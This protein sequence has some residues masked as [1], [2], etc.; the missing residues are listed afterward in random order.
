M[1][2][3][4]GAARRDISPTGPVPL[5]GY[6]RIHRISTGIHDPLLAAA[7]YLENDGHAILLG[8]LD[9]IMLNSDAARR[10]RRRV[11]QQLGLPETAVLISCT[12]THSGPVTARYL[13]FA[14]DPAWPDPDPAYLEFC[15]EQM[16]EA[17][18][19]ARR[20][21]Q[22][23]E[24][25][26]TTAQAP[27]V[28]GNRHSPDGPAD[29]EVGVLAVRSAGQLAAV[30]MIYSMHPT[31]LHE[32]S[33]LVSGDFPAFARACLPAPVVLYHTGPCGD[34]SPR[35]FITS[36][37]FAEAE[38]LGRQLGETVAAQLPAIRYSDNPTLRGAI[39]TADLPPRTIPSV[40]DAQALLE[41]RRREL[42]QLQATGAPR[43]R[44]RTAEVALF[45][46]EAS[47][48]L[49][50]SDV[51]PVRSALLPA[52]V[53]VLQIGE[54]CLVGLPGEIFVAYALELKR[55]APRQTFVVAY[56]NGEL[57]GY[58][59]TPDAT[60]YE[61]SSSLFEPRAGQILVETA[62]RLIP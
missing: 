48:R 7:L 36:Q 46:A 28:G 53:Q 51:E 6:P 38:R 2:L 15:E 22:P 9:V 54:A 57:Q 32:D 37:T 10:L 45:G 17:A 16:L 33:T 31:V 3:R 14:G 55:R 59:V 19:E 24:L 34:Q 5:C 61:M 39:Q 47:L 23:A 18:T 60:G 41:Q 49:A 29:P 12:H 25:G 27:G 42:E 52:D 43:P 20:T 26:W 35:H 62:L 8:A 44:V 4:A 56:A 1:S 40:A 21:A 13:P 11:A 30:A 58:I 50:R